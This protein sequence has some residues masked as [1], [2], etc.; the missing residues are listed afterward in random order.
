VSARR[1]RDSI[2]R[3]HRAAGPERLC[4]VHDE[5]WPCDAISLLDD[6]ERV[7]AAARMQ[8]GAEVALR[9]RIAELEGK[10]RRAKEALR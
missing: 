4:A 5:T 3:E 2:R 6:L 10:I 7:E 1:N 8:A 9:D